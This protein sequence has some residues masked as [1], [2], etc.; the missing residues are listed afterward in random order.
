MHHVPTSATP[1]DTESLNEDFVVARFQLQS[2][3]RELCL[4]S[5]PLYPFQTDK[6]SRASQRLRA[7][8]STFA[9]ATNIRHGMAGQRMNRCG[10]AGALDN[11]IE[12]RARGASGAREFP[13]G[14]SAPSCS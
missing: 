8:V 13:P 6:D 4:V 2:T 10:H 5:E 3:K 12:T 11:E 9:S 7:K 1:H 14:K